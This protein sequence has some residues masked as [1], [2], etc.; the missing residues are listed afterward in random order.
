MTTVVVAERP[1]VARDIARVLGVHRKGGGCLLGQDY[2]VTWALGHLV[3]Y[4]AP[5]EYGT[6]W[7]AYWPFAQLHIVKSTW[8]L[9]T[10]RKTLLVVKK[11]T[12]NPG[13][14]HVIC[15]TDSGREC[16]RT[17]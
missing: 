1:S 8:K 3:E 12:N 6:Q 13:T 4:A 15:T 9:R 2:V 7:A 16:T 11:L 5:D 14:T 10:A 17:Q